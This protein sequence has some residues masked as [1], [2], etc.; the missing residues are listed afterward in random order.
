MSLLEA[1][2]KE[3]LLV[4]LPVL[5]QLSKFSQT[6]LLC[7]PRTSGCSQASFCGTQASGG[8]VHPQKKPCPPKGRWPLF[9]MMHSLDV[10][11]YVCS[12]SG[13]QSCFVFTLNK[14]LNQVAPSFSA[15]MN[16][17]AILFS[18]MLCTPFQWGILGSRNDFNTEEELCPP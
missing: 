1:T 6:L 8:G 16:P 9:K 15:L 12:L 2:G 13:P 4:I 11:L 14:I 17:P 3:G 10:T 5:Q 18:K 7:V